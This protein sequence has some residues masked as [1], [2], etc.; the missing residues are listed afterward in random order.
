MQRLQAHQR[1]WPLVLLERLQDALD[2]AAR[3]EALVSALERRLDQIAQA[4][5][6]HAATASYPSLDCKFLALRN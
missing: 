5:H 1:A 2:V 3:H 6:V 4:R